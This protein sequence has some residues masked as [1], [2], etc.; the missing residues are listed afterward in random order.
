[1][2]VDD[3]R[4][5]VRDDDRGSILAHPLQRVLDLSLSLRVQRGSGLQ[6][7]TQG[8]WSQQCKGVMMRVH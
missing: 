3:S 8:P 5:A 2:R 7:G 4:Q 1:M 6:V